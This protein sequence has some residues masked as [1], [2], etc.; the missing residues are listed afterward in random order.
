MSFAR[1]TSVATTVD[2]TAIEQVPVHAASP[3][4]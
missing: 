4:S 3:T 2:K 1:H